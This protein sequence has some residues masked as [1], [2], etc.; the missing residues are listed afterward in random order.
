MFS[1]LPAQQALHSAKQ[2]C[3]LA[4]QDARTD[5]QSLAAA[6]HELDMAA[7][8]GGPL[9]RPEVDQLIEDVQQLHQQHEDRLDTPP[10]KRLK[11]CSEGQHCGASSA[12]QAQACKQEV[13][14]RRGAHD[15]VPSS[16][17]ASGS[18]LDVKHA[19]MSLHQQQTHSMHELHQLPPGSLQ[20]DS[21]SIGA[22]H[23]PSLER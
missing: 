15:P 8:M 1:D 21:V 22:E 3:K 13:Q 14:G 6:L 23:M 5:Q 11:S 9:F 20:P 7:I 4:D 19:G 2:R 17:A 12:K 18:G 10:A 16:I